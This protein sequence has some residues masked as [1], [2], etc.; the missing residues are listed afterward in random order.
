MRPLL[1]TVHFAAWHTP[2][3]G[4]AETRCARKRRGFNAPGIFATAHVLST[5]R[6]VPRVPPLAEVG[7]ILL[8]PVAPYA[9]VLP[10][11]ISDLLYQ[12]PRRRTIPLTFDPESPVRQRPSIGIRRDRICDATATGSSLE[13]Q[14]KA[15]PHIAPSLRILAGPDHPC[16]DPPTKLL[17]LRRSSP[18][19]VWIRGHRP[20]VKLQVGRA[21]RSA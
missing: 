11:R 19:D 16:H 21:K 20:G 17:T 5:L 14:C 10:S 8:E 6:T 2:R 18:P 7:E 12:L 3:H 4:T 15:L 13:T 1:P 9:F